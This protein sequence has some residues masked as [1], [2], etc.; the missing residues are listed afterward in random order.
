MT[1]GGGKAR[2]SKFGVLLIFPNQIEGSRKDVSFAK[3]DV[4]RVFL[5]MKDN[6]RKGNERSE[7]SEKSSSVD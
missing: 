2:Q 4:P 7:G 5:E 6:E 1:I 3:N